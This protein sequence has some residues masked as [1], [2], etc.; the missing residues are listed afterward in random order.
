MSQMIPQYNNELFYEIYNTYDE[1]ESDYNTWC[2]DSGLYDPDVTPQVDKRPI[3]TGSLKLL[4][5]LLQ[6]KYCNS[7]IAND[8]IN[9]FKIRLFSKV[10]QAGP[11][12]EKRLDIQDKLRK[13]TSDELLIGNTYIN[14]KAINPGTA[15]S[16]GSDDLLPYI[17]EQNANIGKKGIL[18]GYTQLLLLLE[19]DVTEE[20]LNQFKDLF[21]IVVR[22]Q[23]PAL[24]INSIIDEEQE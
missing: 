23:R 15:P 10:F 19:S 12:W 13:L 1:F 20:F 3:T 18:E 7:P 17:N 24:Y 2:E 22:P 5:M 14:N 8:N 9:H 11:F 16:T 21:L 6:G 4:Y